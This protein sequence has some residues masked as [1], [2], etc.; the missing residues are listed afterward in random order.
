MQPAAVAHERAQEVELDRRQVDLL[1]VAAHH[2]RVEVDEQPVDLDRRLA[3][4]VADPPQRGPEPRDQLAR[5][6]RLG[7]VVVGARPRAPRTFASSS[8]TA[9]ST[10]IG[11]DGPLAQL[12]AEL[13]AARRRAA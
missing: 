5:A 2:A 11:I 1:A 3:R 6:E 8:P 10:M 7:H 9:L 12:P 13:D 4:R